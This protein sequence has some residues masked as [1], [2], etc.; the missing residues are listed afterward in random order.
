MVALLM[1]ACLGL[2]QLVRNFQRKSTQG[3][4]VKMVLMWLLGD[5]GKT[6]FFVV[7]SSPAQFYI[8]SS[9]QITIDILILLQVYFYGKKT[10]IPTELDPANFTTKPTI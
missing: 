4:S 9:L 7:R 1:E 6:L 3:M 10:R 2:P 5:V 8:C